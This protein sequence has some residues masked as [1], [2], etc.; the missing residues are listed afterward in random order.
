MKKSLFSNLT[1]YAWKVICQQFWLLAGLSMLFLLLP[2]CAGPVADGLLSDG[3]SFS[4]LTLAVVAPEDDSTGVLL[5]ELTGKMQDVSRYATFHT[6]T[7]SQACQALEDHQVTAILLLPEDFVNGILGGSNP[8][9]TV[10]VREDQPLEALLTYWVGQ[11]AA[12]LLTAAQRGIYAVLELSEGQLPPELS[13]D[14]VV[15][16]I[17]LEYIRMTLNRQ[18]F[19]RPESLSAS[20]TMDTATHYGL[21][22]LIF[23]SLC[24]PPVFR[25]LFSGETL[26]FRRRLL[27][28]GRGAGIQ[29]AGLFCTVFLIL[30]VLT[31]AIT[32]YLTRMN[33]AGWLVLGLF[34]A[35]F[36]CFCC[37]LTRSTAGCGAAAYSLAAVGVFLSGGLIPTPL[38]PRWIQGI[39][40]FSPVGILR[41][42]LYL[43]PEEWE[44]KILPFSL[45]TAALLILSLLLLRNRLKEDEPWDT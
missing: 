33:A 20:D 29:L 7:H 11:S 39:G 2:L 26:P 45:W 18:N 35:A 22:L 4:G 21:S 37:L 23:L 38:L 1:F 32:L 10:V 31:G 12:D 8:D 24:L 17:N 13:R 28:L 43:H 5:E 25:S 44:G 42:M 40:A 16:Q 36:S 14:Q 41:Q 9:V 6:M 27:V 3:V 34:A 19:F 15:M 30:L